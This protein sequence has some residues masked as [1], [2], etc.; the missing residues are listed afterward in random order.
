HAL[1]QVAGPM[2]EPL[3]RMMN[4]QLGAAILIGLQAMGEDSPFKLPDGSV[5]MPVG[6]GNFDFRVE[7]LEDGSFRLGAVMRL[8]LKDVVKIDKTGSPESVSMDLDTSWAEVSLE[9]RV[10]P[11]GKTVRD[12][13][14]PRMRY[15]FTMPFE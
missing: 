12:A 11:D 4:Q 3:T 6:S 8:S 9:L 7:K 5:V 1:Q 15:N 2:A 13:Q 14:P 10:S